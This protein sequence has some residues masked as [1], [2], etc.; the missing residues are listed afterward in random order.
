[1]RGRVRRRRAGLPRRYLSA[2]QLRERIAETRRLTARPYGVNLF[3][4]S[5]A[6]APP[7]TYRAYVERLRAEGALDQGA[8]F[9]FSLPRVG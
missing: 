8:T 7:E 4:P 2:A 9:S 3:V 5:G 6:P 1:M